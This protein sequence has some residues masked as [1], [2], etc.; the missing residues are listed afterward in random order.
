MAVNVVLVQHKR[1]DNIFCHYQL[2]TVR[3]S[4]VQSA[5]SICILIRLVHRND[6]HKPNEAKTIPPEIDML[7]GERVP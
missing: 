1:N 4:L 7:T 3:N 2:F 6:L 5:F